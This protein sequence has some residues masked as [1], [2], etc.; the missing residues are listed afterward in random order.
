MIGD[1][2]NRKHYNRNRSLLCACALV[3]SATVANAVG[4]PEPEP[5]PGIDIVIEGGPSTGRG[6]ATSRADTRPNTEDD[7][8]FAIGVEGGYATPDEK[9]F[10]G[11]D[12]V[13]HN[14]ATPVGIQGTFLY[15]VPHE[16][17]RD[18]ESDLWLDVHMLHVVGVN[19]E[20]ARDAYVEV[21]AV[22][23]AQWYR[24]NCTYHCPQIP[25]P[26]SGVGVNVG[27]VYYFGNVGLT[28]DG[29]AWWDTDAGRQTN[30]AAA[31]GLRWRF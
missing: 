23:E 4:E 27:A 7:G 5:E 1:A 8:S 2:V 29:F 24:H 3:L 19:V 12:I 17:D 10:V 9:P 25:P 11:V 28:V 21:G 26:L 15:L 31:A 13:F 30:L 22:I 14:L 6:E 18:P 16:S 20:V